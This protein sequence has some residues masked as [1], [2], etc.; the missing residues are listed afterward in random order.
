MA[1]LFLAEKGVDN[2]AAGTFRRRLDTC[3]QDTFPAPIFGTFKTARK[4]GFV[5]SGPRAV[6]WTLDVLMRGCL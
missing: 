5:A 6:Y 4:L 1:E 3:F 2:L